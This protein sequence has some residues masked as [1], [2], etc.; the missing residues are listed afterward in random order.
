MIRDGTM[1]LI[2]NLKDVIKLKKLIKMVLKQLKIIQRECIMYNQNSLPLNKMKINQ[3]NQVP[4]EELNK[5]I[6]ISKVRTSANTNKWP[7]D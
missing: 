7:I 2:I 6:L 4:K 3:L 5:I 1:M